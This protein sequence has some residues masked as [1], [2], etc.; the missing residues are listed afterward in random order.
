MQRFYGGDPERWVQ[1]KPPLLSAYAQMLPRLEASEHLSHI[2]AH[3]LSNAGKEA[4]GRI[5]EL[6]RQAEGP[7]RKVRRASLVEI[8][9]LG[10]KVERTS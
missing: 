10:I 1:I 6:E 8:E 5:A 2:E 3:T 4:R 9:S 7:R